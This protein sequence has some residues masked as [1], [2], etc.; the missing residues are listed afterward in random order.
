M[1]PRARPRARLSDTDADATSDVPVRA[2]QWRFDAAADFPFHALEGEALSEPALRSTY[3]DTRDYRLAR[4]GITLCHR[5]VAGGPIGSWALAIR[6]GSER[7]ELEA[8]GDLDAVPSELRRLLVALARDGRLVRVATLITQRTR[9]LV[10]RDG[11]LVAEVVG[12]RVGVV[13]TARPGHPFGQL[14]VELRRAGNEKDARRIVRRLR[15]L[16]AREGDERP[17]LVRALAL[18]LSRP[19]SRSRRHRDPLRQVQLALREQLDQLLAHDPGT[20]LDRD[21][22]DLHAMS[23]AVRRLRAILRSARPLLERHASRELR[24]ELKRL[25]LALGAVD[26]LDRLAAHIRSQRPA[27]PASEHPRVEAV[28]A[29]L[30]DE[31]REAR[32]ALMTVL[33]GPRYLWLL[34]RLEEL[35]RGERQR[36]KGPT[37]RSLAR[38][39]HRRLAKAMR[40]LPADP[41]D[42]ELQR[43]AVKVKRSRDVAEL[44]APS[45][46]RSLARYLARVAELEDVLGLHR[47]AVLAERRIAAAGRAALRSAVAV[48]AGRLAQLEVER[49]ARAREAV[50]EAWRSLRAQA[51]K[52]W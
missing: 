37:L 33:E 44:A 50:S 7:V 47:D 41:S 32:F 52:T 4:A 10:R 34:D 15:K 49:Q 6:S 11:V 25:A 22:D 30:A 9:L 28:V 23:L 51:D 12:D 2:L 21:P 38:R 1:S 40:S 43:V 46:G 35:S 42:V 18:E 31:R 16:G 24:G 45:T 17:E 48:T 26:D 27:L 8:L 20:R 3:L 14:T 19:A 36:R 5:L 39:E 13:D 29:L